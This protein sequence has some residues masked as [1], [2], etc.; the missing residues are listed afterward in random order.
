MLLPKEVGGKYV[1]H[2]QKISDHCIVQYV[3]KFGL[4]QHYDVEGDIFGTGIYYPMWEIH[5]YEKG[6]GHYESWHVEGSHQFEYGNR[7]FVSMFY[8][9]DVEEGGRTVFPYSKAAIKSEVGKHFSFSCSWPYVHYAQTP[10]SDDKYILTSW[11]N[12]VWPQAFHDS[13]QT[14]P[15]HNKQDDYR[16]TKFIFEEAK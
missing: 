1:E 11:M 7:M 14:T 2:I 6:V 5:K 13:F 4:H 16:K 3:N 15:H 12:K 8:L 9:N 10:V